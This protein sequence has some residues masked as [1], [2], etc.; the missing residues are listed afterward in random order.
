MDVASRR[1]IDAYWAADVGLDVAS[2]RAPG[3]VAAPAAEP[4]ERPAFFVFAHGETVIVQAPHKVPLP[5]PPAT[6]ASWLDPAWWAVAWPHP[7]QA[8]GPAWLGFADAGD[9]KRVDLGGARPLTAGDHAALEA[10]AAEVEPWAWEHAGIAPEGRQLGVLVG[11][12]IVSV[13]QILVW[14]ERLGHVGIVTHPAHRGKG[15][16]RAAVAFATRVGV[17]DGLVMQYRTL[18]ANTASVAVARR[19]GFEHVATTLAIRI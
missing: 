18:A 6:P 11:G 7:Q 13:A 17:A 5:A 19:L 16:A 12:A 4:A 8:I 14:G 1:I 9:L 15:Y 10:L 2:F 3:F